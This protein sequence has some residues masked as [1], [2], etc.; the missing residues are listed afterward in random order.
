MAPE[1]ICRLRSC[2]IRPYAQGDAESLSRAADNPKIVQWMTNAFPHPYTLEDAKG[3]VTSCSSASPMHDFA[4]C[5]PT[6]DGGSSVIGGVGLKPGRDIYH[7]R[8]EIGYWVSE[9]HWNK[10]IATEAVK[11]FSDWAFGAFDHVVRLDAYVFEG[12]EGSTRVLERAG[13]V[14][15]SR[16]KDA[17][18]KYGEVKDSLVYRKLRRGE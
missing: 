13:Y 6:A 8:M 7:R 15:E 11:A 12:N 3:W 17:I 1:P 18:E 9:D 2:V 14:L 10:G 5:Q 4:I 16:Q